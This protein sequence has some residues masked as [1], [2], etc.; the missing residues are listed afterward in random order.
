MVRLDELLA[1]VSAAAVRAQS[2][3]DAVAA[4][5][6]KQMA[7]DPL[8]AQLPLS[9]MTLESVEMRIPV[10]LAPLGSAI[11]AGGDSLVREIAGELARLADELP[12]HPVLAALFAGTERLL[13][14]WLAGRGWLD[15]AVASLLRGPPAGRD[16]LI[17]QIADRF[18]RTP[19]QGPQP[20]RV[21]YDPRTWFRRL[22]GLEPS[23]SQREAL[24]QAIGGAIDAAV[25]RKPI[26]AAAA[27]A[28]GA[29]FPGTA[30]PPMLGLVVCADEIDQTDPRALATLTVV[31]KP[32]LSVAALIERAERNGAAAGTSANAP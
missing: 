19:G 24:K 10:A 6:A 1:A 3:A 29:S 7:S 17:D 18:L 27:L 9:C 31:L 30:P 5:L 22:P 15:D 14:A 28:A 32:G 26:Q 21:W 13:E 4:S 12:R 16:A 8:L 25:G 23:A 11:A 2:E 20:R